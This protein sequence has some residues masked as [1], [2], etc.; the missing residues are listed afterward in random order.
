VVVSNTAGLPEAAALMWRLGVKYGIPA[1]RMTYDALG[2]G[3]P[4][5]NHLSRHGLQAAKPYAGESSPQDS[6]F[7]NLRTEAAWRLRNRLD[8]TY[9]PDMRNPHSNVHPFSIPCADFWPRLRE[10]LRP[11]TYELHKHQTKLLPKKDWCE[12]LGHSPDIA[13]TLIQSFSW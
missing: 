1:E 6:S 10:E 4:M 7:T 13:D 12:L 11:L 2:V 3:K 5:P 9:I 8:P